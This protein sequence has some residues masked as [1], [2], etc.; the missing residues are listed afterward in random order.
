MT[1]ITHKIQVSWYSWLCITTIWLYSLQGHLQ[2][3]HNTLY[4]RQILCL[5][6]FDWGRLS[7]RRD[8]SPIPA[9][10]FHN[11]LASVCDSAGKSPAW[12]GLDAAIPSHFVM[13]DVPGALPPAR[14]G[15][16]PCRGGLAIFDA[17]CGGLLVWI[18]SICYFAFDSWRRQRRCGID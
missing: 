11:E 7:G 8:S 12:R 16:F 13:V 4:S 6:R 1:W 3:I 14:S 9:D 10:N 2:N 5:P 15:G 18:S 17:G